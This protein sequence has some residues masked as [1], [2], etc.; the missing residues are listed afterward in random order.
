MKILGRRK[1]RREAE[2]AELD[3]FRTY[4]HALRDDVTTFGEQLTELHLDTLAIELDADGL[5]DYQRALDC[6]EEAKRQLRAAG[7]TTEVEAVGTT[8]ADGRFARAR[9]LARQDGS[10]LPHRRDPCFFDP[11]HG[12]A[13]TD[14]RWTPQGGVERNIPVCRADANRLA[15]GE[16][17]LVRIV[18]TA[19]G[20]VPWYAADAW[21]H[22]APGAGHAHVHG[23]DTPPDTLRALGEAHMRRGLSNGP[24]S[25][26]GG[27]GI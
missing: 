14:V 27:G 22:G 11:Q 3:R 20:L 1:A 15:N 19:G 23:L 2:L 26:G 9:V 5:A 25:P 13:A 16:L 12:P 21:I 24:A 6:Y 8:L 17:P 18:A 7:S 10:D 4:R